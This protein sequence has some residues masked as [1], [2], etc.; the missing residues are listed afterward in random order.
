MKTALLSCVLILS[1]TGNAFAASANTSHS[2]TAK[3]SSSHSSTAKSSSS[4]SSTA[5]ADYSQLEK[6]LGK[7]VIALIQHADSVCSFQMASPKH[8][9]EQQIAGYPILSELGELNSDLKTQLKTVLLNDKH[10]DFKL[11]NRC[12]FIPKIAYLFRQGTNSV[13]VLTSQTCDIVEIH[14]A[15]NKLRIDNDPAKSQWQKLTEQ[16][17]TSAKK[18]KGDN[19]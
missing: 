14:A 19:L 3:S 16:T 5:S 18:N 7:D 13:I 17:R 15:G 12:L 4:N 2:S 10:Y 6:K 9:M 8:K 1:M 11:K